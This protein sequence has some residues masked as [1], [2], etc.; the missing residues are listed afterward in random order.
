MPTTEQISAVLGEI[1]D[2]ELHRGLNELNMV[3][4]IDDRG[5]AGRR[6]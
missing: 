6:C 4:N 3:R 5:L 2:P 1:Q